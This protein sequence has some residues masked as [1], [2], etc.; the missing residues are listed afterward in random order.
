MNKYLPMKRIKVQLL[1][2]AREQ[3]VAHMQEIREDQVETSLGMKFGIT[4][5]SR[6]K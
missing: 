3:R 2:I 1:A 5:S 6:T 4:I